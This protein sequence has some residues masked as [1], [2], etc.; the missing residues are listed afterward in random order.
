MEVVSSGR[1]N[2]LIGGDPQKGFSLL[3]LYLLRSRVD[4]DTEQVQAALNDDDNQIERAQR[5]V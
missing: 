4:Q 2:H 1:G 5:D 3:F